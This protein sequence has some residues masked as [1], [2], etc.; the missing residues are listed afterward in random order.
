MP[1]RAYYVS[2]VDKRT[3]PWPQWERLQPGKEAAFVEPRV[4]FLSAEHAEWP[5]IPLL[6]APD[7]H[8]VADARMGIFT[9]PGIPWSDGARAGRLY[10][11]PT[12]AALFHPASRFCNLKGLD[13]AYLLYQPELTDGSHD[14][15]RDV[16]E[17][18]GRARKVSDLAGRL[19]FVPIAG[20]TDP[21]DHAKIIHAIEQW[22]RRSDPFNYGGRGASKTTTRITINLSPGTPSMH[23][24]WLILRW[25]GALGKGQSLIEF[26]Q[27]DGGLRGSAEEL[28]DPLRVVPIDVLAQWIEPSTPACGLAIPHEAGI[29]LEEL[30]GPPYDLL[31]QKIDRAALLGLPVLLLGERGTGK[32][33]LA[34]YYHQRRHF[35]REQRGEFVA[36]KKTA[37]KEAATKTEVK[38]SIGL[39]PPNKKTEETFIPVTLSEFAS[40][41]EL[42]DTLFGWAQ[43]A[44]NLAFEAN[45]GLLGEAHNGT[46]FLDE[47]HHLERSLQA[48][49][50]GPLNARRYR[51]KMAD[52]EIV[53]NF[54]LVVATN[55]PQWR[56]RLADDFRDRIER[57]VVEVP[58]FRSFQRVGGD[59]LW[60]FWDFTLRKRCAECGIEYN[61]DGP[62]W[63]AC[64]E[65][66]RGVLKRHP[67]TGNWRDL[68]RLADN[69]LLHLTVP[70]DGRPSPLQ[71]DCDLLERAI[72]ETFSEP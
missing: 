58:S 23:A 71:W 7:S 52:Y 28:R 42:R 46:L 36:P 9:W 31:R 18:V 30:Q 25:N 44:W 16:L 26:V 3:D 63:R 43:G 54:D 62:A 41:D 45:D 68:Q 2:W 50:L 47:I 72:D 66:L 70:R 48:S 37:T 51:P 67:L 35:Y 1:E 11:G 34:R 19:Q 61:E 29:L 59:I 14:R 6:E 8:Q 22:V 65:L 49:L 10:T 38:K 53:S 21:T 57:I 40:V 20:I 4:S 27:G 15:L 5:G 12:L 56:S 69:V 32:T 33:S 24:S 55:D 39:R 13:R 60:A 64:G 17:K